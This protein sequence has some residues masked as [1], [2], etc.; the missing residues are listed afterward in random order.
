MRGL[1]RVRFLDG[2]AEGGS[3]SDGLSKDVTDFVA[4]RVGKGG[5]RW[6]RAIQV[7]RGFQALGPD[8]ETRPSSAEKSPDGRGRY[9][10]ARRV[11]GHPAFAYVIPKNGFVLLRLPSNAADGAKFAVARDVADKEPFK[12]KCPITTPAAAEEAIKLGAKAYELN[13]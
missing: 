13:G 4:S 3:G 6:D 1:L 2:D 9:V 7:I 11:G 8:V 10:W 5:P 12:V